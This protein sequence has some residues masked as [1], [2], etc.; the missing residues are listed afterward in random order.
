MPLD[1]DAEDLGLDEDSFD[2]DEGIM[3][4]S[5]D[6]DATTGDNEGSDNI[7]KDV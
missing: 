3:S 6:E 7:F 1:M 5:D 4:E 2:E